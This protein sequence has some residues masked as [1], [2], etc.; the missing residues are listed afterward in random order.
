MVFVGHVHRKL[1][2]YMLLPPLMRKMIILTSTGIAFGY[3]QRHAD[4]D[5]D[6][7]KLALIVSC[8][9]KLRNRFLTDSCYHAVLLHQP[10]YI[11][12][13]HQSDQ[14]ERRETLPA[15]LLPEMVRHPL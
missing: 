9:A 10:D 2:R 11:Q 5:P 12:V 4:L 6:E 15:H 8:D 7:A 1:L 3:G 13:R 14:A